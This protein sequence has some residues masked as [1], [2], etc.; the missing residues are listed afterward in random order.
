[1]QTIAVSNFRA[2]IMSFLKQVENGS[3]IE[4]TSHGKIV[5]KL[6]PPDFIRNDAKQKLIKVGKNAKMFD[7][8]SSIDEVWNA[9][10]S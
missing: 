10:K 4:I 3:S 6:I 7:V 8:I 9:E 5:A 1:M 2:K